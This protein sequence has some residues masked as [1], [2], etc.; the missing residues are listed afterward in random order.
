MIVKFVWFFSIS[1]LEILYTP[2]RIIFLLIQFH[3][4]CIIF[5]FFCL[6]FFSCIT[7]FSCVLNLEAFLYQNQGIL[8][9]KKWETCVV[10][11]RLKNVNLDPSDI[12]RDQKLGGDIFWGRRDTAQ[13]LVVAMFPMA[14]TSTAA[15]LGEVMLAQW[16]I[17]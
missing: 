16:V 9:L 5:G 17:V 4:L 6:I 15:Q 3:I 14:T 12:L 8:G 13:P 1:A 7:L 10:L 2:N 11:F